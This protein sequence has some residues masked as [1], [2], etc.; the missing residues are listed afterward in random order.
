ML[1]AG[2]VL[3]LWVDC[4]LR[5]EFLAFTGIF[6]DIY[7]AARPAPGF[8]GGR[9]RAITEVERGMIVVSSSYS[10]ELISIFDG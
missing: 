8:M 5:E 1:E 3:G 7:L 4:S 2:F 10:V 9:R 6:P